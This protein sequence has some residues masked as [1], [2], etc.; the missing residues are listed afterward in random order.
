VKLQVAWDYSGSGMQE[1]QYVPQDKATLSARY[2]FGFGMTPF[3]SV[4][5]VANTR[6]YTKKQDGP[7]QKAQM[8]DYAV[9]NL[10]LSQKLLGERLLL[11]V[12]ADN[13]LNLELE[14][15]YGIPRPGRFVFGGAEYRFKAW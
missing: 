15:S 4:V 3:A 11:F 8:T 13:L 2:D 1:L 12:G 7:I 6:V 10:K 9:V 14:Q 5:Y